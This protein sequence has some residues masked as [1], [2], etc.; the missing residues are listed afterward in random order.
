M[1]PDETGALYRRHMRDHRRAVL[2]TPT[3]LPQLL[4]AAL[5]LARHF[6]PHRAGS[7]E[8]DLEVALGPLE[9]RFPGGELLLSRPKLDKGG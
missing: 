8:H 1:P 6:G 4:G 7:P 3:D 9:P 2:D 5:V